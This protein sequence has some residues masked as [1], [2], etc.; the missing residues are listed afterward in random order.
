MSSASESSVDEER[1]QSSSLLRNSTMEAQADHSKTKRYNT[2]YT[3]VTVLG[4]ALIILTFFWLSHFL[5]GFSLSTPSTEF[6]WH[7]LLMIIGMIF[8]YSQSILV[9]RTGRN[10]P[11]F[12]LKLIHAIIHIVIFVLV[13]LAQKAVF[14][15]HNYAKPPIPNLYSLH[16]WVGVLT[17]L[18]FVCQLLLGFT[19]FLYPG[20][21]KNFRACILPYHVVIGYSG[22]IMALITS[23][24][25][26]MEKVIFSL[27]NQYQQLPASGVLVNL[28]GVIL[29]IFGLLTIHLVT[30]N[31]YKRE[32]GSE[33]GVAL[34]E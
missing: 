34:S 21:S 18:L 14:D 31:D 27:S 12:K 24:L 32:E 15:S 4:V 22:F 6:N 17:V 2:I 26:F 13:I 20:A 1:A 30:N 9:Y 23:A 33:E 19:S 16:S 25:G 10:V 7:P 8:L 29:V 3:T 11:K 5:G 28:I